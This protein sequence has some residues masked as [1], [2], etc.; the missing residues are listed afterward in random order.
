MLCDHLLNYQNKISMDN[1][2]QPMEPVV[3]LGLWDPDDVVINEINY[4]YY[5]QDQ[6]QKAE[7]WEKLGMCSNAV[8]D[9][10]TT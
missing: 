7:V 5:L 9:R 2:S 3:Q 6:T 8:R 10:M 1:C 4:R